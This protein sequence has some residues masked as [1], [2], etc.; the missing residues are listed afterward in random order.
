MRRSRLSA[1]PDH[2]RRHE[3]GAPAPVRALRR[4]DSPDAG[5]RGHDGRRVRRPGDVPGARGVLHA[6][7]VREPG[8]SR[9]APA[10]DGRRDPGGDGR[11]ARRVRRRDRHGGNRHR[12]G[13]GAQGVRARRANRRRRARTLARA[14]GG[15]LSAPRHPGHR[16]ILR[17]RRAQPGDP[18]RD[19]AGA[20]R[21]CHGDGAPAGPR[22]RAPRRHLG[23][24]QCLGG[25]PGRRA[26]AAGADRRHG[27]VRYWGA[28]LERRVLSAA[29]VSAQPRAERRR[30]ERTGLHS[31][32][33][34]AGHEQPGPPEPRGVGCGGAAG[35][36]G[37]DLRRAQGSRAERAGRGSRPREHLRQQRGHRVAARPG[38]A[39][40]GRRRGVDHPR[41]R[42]RVRDPGLNDP[43]PCMIS[44]S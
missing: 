36:A 41:A 4:R 28:V 34:P 9:G 35:R 12:R 10:H 20:R 26:D 38:D 33:V 17:A 27:A 14:L 40:Q 1:H 30:H 18:R 31:D 29:H 25:L 23:G 21:G 2:A 8:Q 5:H 39:A 6:D 13:R 15:A 22:G 7:A 37:G 3:R 19:R 24:R 42:R 16:R 32:A 44:V 43:A 11:A